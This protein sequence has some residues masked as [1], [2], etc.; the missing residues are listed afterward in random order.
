MLEFFPDIL[1][2]DFTAKMEQDLDNVEDGKVPWVEIID[3]F[4]QEFEK[5]LAKQKRKC[6]LLK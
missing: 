4:Y 2:I 1:N 5:H 6:S 3:E